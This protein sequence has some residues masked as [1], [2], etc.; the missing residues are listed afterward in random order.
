MK[1]SDDI[2]QV[3]DTTN[4][5][6]EPEGDDFLEEKNYYIIGID[7]AQGESQTPMSAPEEPRQ[8][9]KKKC[10]RYQCQYHLADH[11]ICIFDNENSADDYWW[12]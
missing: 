3:I 10:Y 1:R 11:N 2:C 7:L 4:E 12:E 9:E 8:Q 5:V 6:A